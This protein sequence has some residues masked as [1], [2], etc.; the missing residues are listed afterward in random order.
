MELN[1]EAYG[2]FIVSKNVM[3]GKAIRYSF[4]EKSDIPEL[5]GWTLYSVEDDDH[6]VNDPNNFSIL[7][8]ESVYEMSPV[9]IEIFDAPYGTDLC[10]LYEEDVHVGFYD[11]NAEKEIDIQEILEESAPPCAPPDSA[12]PTPPPISY[13][14]YVSRTYPDQEGPVIVHSFGYSPDNLFAKFGVNSETHD[15]Y[16]IDTTKTA[17]AEAYQLVTE[18]LH[19]FVMAQPEHKYPQKLVIEVDGVSGVE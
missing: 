4:R 19:E 13:P 1:N 7:S 17:G 9:I 11:L 14:I 15:P 10:W 18:G 2:G 8:A 6:Y 3:A 12:F 16:G 5:N